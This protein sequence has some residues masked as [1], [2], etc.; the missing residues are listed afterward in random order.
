[1]IIMP[2]RKLTRRVT[3]YFEDPLKGEQIV[4]Y[5]T[6]PK[7][8]E[9]K[10]VT[11]KFS[12]DEKSEIRPDDGT[13][14]ANSGHR[15]T[16]SDYSKAKGKSAETIVLD[17]ASLK[18]IK[19]DY[20]CGCKVKSNEV[21]KKNLEKFIAQQ[22]NILRKKAT[23]GQ[24]VDLLLGKPEIEGQKIKGV[25][26]YAGVSLNNRLYLPEELSKGDGMTLPLIINHAAVD[27]AE[28]ELY[29][30]NRIPQE[31]IQKLEKGEEI[32]VGEVTLTWDSDQ[33]ILYYEGI[34]EDPFWIK[35]IA[36]GNMAVSLGMY[37][38]ADSPTICNKACYT[39]IQNGEFHE[40]SLVWHP[41]FAI[42]TIEAVEAVLKK[43]AWEALQ[44]ISEAVGPHSVGFDNSIN[45]PTSS[46]EITG[47]N[48]T[49]YHK[50]PSTLV[51]KTR[52]NQNMKP[53]SLG[54]VIF[55]DDDEEEEKILKTDKI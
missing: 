45:T 7:Q 35:E 41:G 17:E 29:Y 38:D 48:A 10:Q 26:A 31:I 22:I 54:D 36:T 51:A 5:F 39:V 6:D 12:E 43:R 14:I 1:M 47:S 24:S 19:W 37:Y 28:E 3:E 8:D 21:L 11:D 44:D 25:L 50:P 40:V 13:T 32:K 15:S 42:A 53:S 49:Q 2:I 18:Q 16:Y 34:V 52:M 46:P 23:E 30:G 9:P 4:E 27:G 20:D 33:N 55:E